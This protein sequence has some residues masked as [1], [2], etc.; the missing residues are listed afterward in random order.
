MKDF[1]AALS[2]YVSVRHETLHILAWP[3]SLFGFSSNSIQKNPNK[4]LGQP[5]TSTVTMYYNKLNAEYHY[6]IQWASNQKP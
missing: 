1:S 3:K 2:N 5:S 4:L 6:S